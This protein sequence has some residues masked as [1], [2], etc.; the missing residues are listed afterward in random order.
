MLPVLVTAL[1]RDGELEC[2]NDEAEL[3]CQMRPATIDRRL[4]PV[5]RLLMIRGRI[6]TKPGTLLKSQIPIRTWSEW[7]D[8]VPPFVEIDLVGHEG[9]YP[10]GEFCFTLTMTDVTTG[11]TVNCS[12]PNKAAVFVT[13]AIEHAARQFPFPILASTR[14]VKLCRPRIRALAGRRREASRNRRLPVVVVVV[15]SERS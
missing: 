12:V 13:E 2:S 9:G 3:L 4:A 1:R 5:R 8:A 11:F 6:H 14:T 15:R 7:D 10:F